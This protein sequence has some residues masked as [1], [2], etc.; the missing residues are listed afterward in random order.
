M[1]RHL[2]P[3]LPNVKHK[4]PNKSVTEFH[5]IDIFYILR[6]WVSIIMKMKLS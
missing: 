2:S 4:K 5:K 6:F 1:M 3:Y